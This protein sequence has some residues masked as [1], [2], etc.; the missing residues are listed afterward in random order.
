MVAIL[1]SFDDD[2]KWQ[3][4]KKSPFREFLGLMN[5]V[6]PNVSSDSPPDLVPF[7]SL[8][9]LGSQFLILYIYIYILEDLCNYVTM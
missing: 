2:A 1:L 8:L 5:A 9:D 6:S 4:L 3:R 7:K